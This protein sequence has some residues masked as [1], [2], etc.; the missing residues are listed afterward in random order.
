MIVRFLHGGIRNGVTYRGTPYLNNNTTNTKWCVAFLTLTTIQQT[1]T[2]RNDVTL[3]C[4]THVVVPAREPVAAAAITAT[5]TT[6]QKKE[7]QQISTKWRLHLRTTTKQH[8]M[9]SASTKRR[10]R[11][12]PDVVVTAREPVAAAAAAVAATN[13]EGAVPAGR[14][15][16]PLHVTAVART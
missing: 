14:T 3:R 5:I 12:V 7:Q 2:I 4:T 8:E 16:V 11:H 15:H 1:K 10:H 6:K 9:A 13:N